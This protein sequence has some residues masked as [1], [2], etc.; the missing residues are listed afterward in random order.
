MPNVELRMMK[1]QAALFT[2]E[3][4]GVMVAYD[5]RGLTKGVLIVGPETAAI[6][7]RLQAEGARL[8]AQGALTL[9]LG[10]ALYDRPFLFTPSLVIDELGNVIEG[11]AA[12]DWLRANA[13]DLPRSEVFGIDARGREDQVFAR[14]VDVESSPIV[15]GGPDDAPVYVAALIGWTELPLRFAAALKVVPAF[16][17]SEVRKFVEA[18]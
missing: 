8:I 16:E 14:E 18:M 5:V 9:R 17:G 15:I 2:H 3:L 6:A 13:Y 4:N 10:V 1:G 7:R 11:E 12:F